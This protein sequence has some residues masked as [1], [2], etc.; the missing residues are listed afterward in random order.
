MNQ[1]E[2]IIYLDNNATT[3]VDSRVADA[4]QYAMV[5]AFGN[6]A[7]S[8]HA[9]GWEAEQLVKQA[10]DQIASVVGA[11]SEEV[12]FTSGATESNNISLFGLKPSRLIT[13]ETE[14]AAVL[15]PAQQ[16]R[17]SGVDVRLIPVNASGEID[18]QKFSQALIDGSGMISIMLANNE[19]GVIHPV[20]ELAA[21]AHRFGYLVHCDATQALG[22]IDLSFKKLGV[23]LMSISAHKCYGPKGVGALIKRD[24]I[25]LSPLVIGGGQEAGVRAGTLNVP[26]I[27][28]FGE[29]CRIIEAERGSEVERIGRLTERFFSS[30]SKQC[31]AIVLNGPPLK[32]RLPGNLN[33]Q[34]G[35]VSA[36]VV[37]KLSTK[38][39]FSTS[40][41]CHSKT[42]RP[43]HVLAA[44]GLTLKEQS[45]SVRIGIGRF[46]TESEIDRAVEL[47]ATA[48]RSAE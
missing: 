45:Q 13:V 5:D 7:S 29:A 24:G 11:K 31:P 17:K 43:S 47:F 48:M 4:V 2:P 1:R 20:A 14:H 23:D 34:L 42:S 28:G 33:I 41:A 6:P 40:S 36:G 22:K 46:N 18:R 8:T 3:Q 27:V 30:L 44:M 26:G 37:G 25:N 19:V 35:V 16:M 10:R 12:T 32:S 38:V 39:A 21:E 9:L 15:E